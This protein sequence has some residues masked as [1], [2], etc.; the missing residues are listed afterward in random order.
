MLAAQSNV[1]AKRRRFRHDLP[2]RRIVVPMDFSGYARQALTCAVPL[3][4]RHHAKISLVHVVR[5]TAALRTSPDGSI[6]LPGNPERLLS[7]AQSHL[8]ELAARLVPAE[9]RG[10]M[11][12]REGY[13]AQEVIATARSLKSDLIV[14]S[15][16]GR[17]GL[18]R[19]VL[20]STAEQIVRHAHC[21]V[22]TVRRRMDESA[23]RL[24][25]LRPPL[26]PRRLSWR[27]ILV[28]LDFSLTSLRALSVAMPL[29]RASGARLLL[30]NVVEPSPYPA[31]MEATV[32][33]MPDTALTRRAKAQLHKVARRLTA[34]SHRVS[35]LVARGRA[36]DK[37]V[38]TAEKR[39][40]DLIVLSTHG[41]TG[42]DRFLMGSV[43]EQVI[44]HARCP[45]LVVRKTPGS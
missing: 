13:P 5:P 9:S 8:E 11:I 19:V 16:T 18:S 24:L 15:N 23:K 22:L 3:A 35:S 7:A 43:A 29:A 12:V 21:P 10:Q 1:A 38:E 31:G 4:R 32:L 42:L 34:N 14:L 45:V 41:L 25:P 17:S 27:R 37:I 6:T 33:V 44:R 28:P 36:A 2:F 20:G 40:V 30:L 39:A 26:Y